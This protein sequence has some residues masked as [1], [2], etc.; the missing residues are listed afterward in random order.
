ML[1]E[2]FG[3]E[4]SSIW[5]MQREQAQKM[6]MTMLEFDLYLKEHKNPQNDL[7]YENY[8]KSLDLSQNLILEA[9]TGFYCQPKS[10]KIFLDVDK[11]VAGK[12]VFNAHRTTE[13]AYA[14][15]EDAIKA[16]ELRNQTARD[17]LQKL[18]DIDIWDYKNFD[19]VIDTNER[20]PEEIFEI[21]LKEFQAWKR[22]KVESWDA[23]YAFLHT[24]EPDLFTKEET[25]V[26]SKAKHK[27]SLL[28]NI[29][30]LLA[31]MVI[32]GFWIVTVML[33]R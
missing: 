33:N 16:T 15:V 8:W 22:K 32:A 1:A 25:K 27:K 10:F 14:C 26:L 19:L 5:A 17:R 18:Y 4:I 12:R 23:D 24:S 31:L 9:R 6:G 7:Q 28:K 11:D 21:I 30:L 3:Y 20:T 29:L 2:H 13:T